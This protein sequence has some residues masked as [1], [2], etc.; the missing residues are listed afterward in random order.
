MRL[1]KIVKSSNKLKK[2]DAY[3]MLDNGRQKKVSFGAAGYSDY[4]INKDDDRKELY[5][6]RHRSR[7]N[8]NNPLTAG[9]LSRWILW[10]KKTL[11]AAITAFKKRFKL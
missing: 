4:T 7:E 10:E 1:I 2:Y 11:K 5:I 3:F 9:A 8:W 6:R